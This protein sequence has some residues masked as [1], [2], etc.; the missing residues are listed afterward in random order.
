MKR[1]SAILAALILGTVL[2]GC[3]AD[4]RSDCLPCNVLGI[5]RILG[6]DPNAAM[7]KHP[8]WF[9]FPLSPAPPGAGVDDANT[10]PER[11]D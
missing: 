10:G 3:T 7:R 9:G 1:L 4:Q 6:D 11:S 8:A 2:S 5:C